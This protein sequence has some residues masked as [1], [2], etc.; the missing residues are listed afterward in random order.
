MLIHPWDATSG[1]D[2]WRAFVVAQSFG[3]LIAAG[4]DRE[5]P[6]VVPTQ[7]LLDG[8]EVLLHLARP[9]PIW[10]AIDENPVVLLSIAGDWAYIPAAWKAI[11]DE[12]PALG[13]PTTYYA[14]VQLRCEASIVDDPA[15]KLDILRSQLGVVEPH[16]GHADPGVHERKLAGIR[17]LRLALT[18]V[19]GKFK[20]GGNVDEAHREAIAANLEQRGGAGDLTARAHLRRRSRSD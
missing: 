9:N 17:G 12:D 14:A 5:V 11:G 13:I 2:E 8:D 7:F 1:D 15:A 20:Y 3:Q 4:R 10:H 18:E 19:S 16:S 6:V